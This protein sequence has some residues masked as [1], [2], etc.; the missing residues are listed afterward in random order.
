MPSNLIVML[1]NEKTLKLSD[2]GKIYEYPTK[3]DGKV[4]FCEKILQTAYTT[5][6]SNVTAPQVSPHSAKCHS[7]DT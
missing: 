4:P 7:C 1:Q 2:R 3:P 6:L 5:S